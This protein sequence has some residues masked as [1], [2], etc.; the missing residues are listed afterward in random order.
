LEV[1]SGFAEKG[2]TLSEL[3]HRL[4]QPSEIIGALVTELLQLGWLERVSGGERLVPGPRL[5]DC[6]TRLLAQHFWRSTDADEGPS[7]VGQ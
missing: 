6:S 3:A 2:L 1:V 5:R 4:D 7:A